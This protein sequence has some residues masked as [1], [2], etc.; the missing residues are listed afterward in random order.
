MAR[1]LTPTEQRL[2]RMTEI[3]LNPRMDPRI[4]DRLLRGILAGSPYKTYVSGF[5]VLE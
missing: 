4:K 3:I 1:G 2:N 5:G